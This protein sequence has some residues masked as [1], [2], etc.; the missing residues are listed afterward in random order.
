MNDL[1]LN[2]APNIIYANFEQA[3]QSAVSD[4]FPDVIRKGCR[5]HLRQSIWRKIQSLGLSTV[6]KNKSEVGKL[7]SNRFGLSFLKP[8]EVKKCFYEDLMAIKPN[9]KRVDNFF[10]YF[11]KFIF[12]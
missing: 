9:D 2:F 6:F 4:I 8:D 12:R 3:I 10:N 1:N 7:N 5:F 11:E